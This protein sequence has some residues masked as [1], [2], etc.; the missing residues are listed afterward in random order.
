[1]ASCR[2]LA[3]TAGFESVCEAMVMGK[4]VLMVPIRGQYEQQ[5]NA[6]DA[7]RAGAGIWADRFNL[8]LLLQYLPKYQA[9]IKE[10]RAWHARG[11]QKLLC[12]LESAARITPASGPVPDASGSTTAG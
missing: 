5:C 6:L 2:A 12:L 7:A 9:R 1:M 10:T 4:P 11:R 3:T 8:D